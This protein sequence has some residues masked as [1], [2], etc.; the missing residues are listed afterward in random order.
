MGWKEK[1]RPACPD[2]LLQPFLW[3]HWGG[4][5]R[6]WGGYLRYPKT[7]QERRLWDEE[8]GRAKRSPHNLVNAWD[9]IGRSDATHRSW[10]RHRKTQWK[11]I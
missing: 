8:Y 3:W 6:H 7:T 1:N 10:K 5:K 2:G 11:P 4:R 9:D